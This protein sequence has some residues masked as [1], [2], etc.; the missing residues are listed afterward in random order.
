MAVTILL[1][2]LTMVDLAPFLCVFDGSQIILLPSRTCL[3]Y[4]IC[5]GRVLRFLRGHA[6]DIRLQAQ[7]T[8]QPAL[9][10]RTLIYH[11]LRKPVI[12][13]TSPSSQLKFATL[14]I[15]AEPRDRGISRRHYLESKAESSQFTKAQLGRGRYPVAR[16]RF[17]PRQPCGFVTRASSSIRTGIWH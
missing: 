3:L 15:A 8:G 13:P 16:Q 7:I 11:P 1:R 17:Q 9:H 12:L 10:F 14:C 5:A 6:C 4:G 2:R